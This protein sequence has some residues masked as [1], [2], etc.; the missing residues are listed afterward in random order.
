M[1]SR[2]KGHNFLPLPCPRSLKDTDLHGGH[3]SP[4][5]RQRSPFPDA[6]SQL[7]TAPNSSTGVLQRQE[8]HP[9][10]QT[11]A[12]T[13]DLPRRLIHK[14]HPRHGAGSWPRMRHLA[15]HTRWKVQVAAVYLALQRAVAQ[16]ERGP[17]TFPWQEA[18]LES[19]NNHQW[20]GLWFT[21]SLDGKPSLTPCLF[22][23]SPGCKCQQSSHY[24]PGLHVHTHQPHVEA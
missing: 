8:K 14:A 4:F 20:S 7:Q 17:S 22:Q 24:L 6:L 10:P 9:Q 11:A 2:V 23:P 21:A 18:L 16:A 19:L 3:P 13:L 5:L 15:E 1:S 12:I